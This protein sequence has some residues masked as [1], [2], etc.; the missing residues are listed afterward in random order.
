MLD[1]LSDK[2]NLIRWRN[3]SLYDLRKSLLIWGYEMRE[4]YA[5]GGI[6]CHVADVQDMKGTKPYGIANLTFESD[7][8]RGYPG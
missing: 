5:N 7:K 2:R 3:M 1:N 6:D 4:G 8:N